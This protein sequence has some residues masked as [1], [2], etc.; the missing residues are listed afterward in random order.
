MGAYALIEHPPTP[1]RTTGTGILPY[2]GTGI[3]PYLY[4]VFLWFFYGSGLLAI[5]S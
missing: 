3:L 2:F 1:S 4:T 5:V